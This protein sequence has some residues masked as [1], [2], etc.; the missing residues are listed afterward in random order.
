MHDCT[1]GRGPNGVCAATVF[2]CARAGVGAL[3]AARCCFTLKTSNLVHH[4]AVAALALLRRLPCALVALHGRMPP[5]LP[6]LRDS[7]EFRLET[8][9][10]WSI[11]LALGVIC[12]E[13]SAGG[14]AS[15]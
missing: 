11:L 10:D 4:A 8:G 14:G 6:L 1:G 2:N 3:Q 5:P 9:L 7:F 13:E 12:I 15:N